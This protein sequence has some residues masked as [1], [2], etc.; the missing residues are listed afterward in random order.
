MVLAN[1]GQRGTSFSSG[2]TFT[3]P[4]GLD[5]NT[6]SV[7]GGTIDFGNESGDPIDVVLSYNGATLVE[8]MTN[9]VTNATY[10]TTYAENLV[11]LTGGTSAYVGFTGATG[12]IGA[13]NDQQLHLC[14]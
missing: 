11:S 2:G 10:S 3:E 5:P 4:A 9:T 6:Q 13:A 14:S 12:G 8:S 1:G 7:S